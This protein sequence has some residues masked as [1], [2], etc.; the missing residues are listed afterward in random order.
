MP[1]IAILTKVPVYSGHTG[2]A[3]RWRA[4]W[5]ESAALRAGADVSLSDAEPNGPPR[6]RKGERP[7]CA[8]SL[9]PAARRGVQAPRAARAIGSRSVFGRAILCGGRARRRWRRRTRARRRRRRR[10]LRRVLSGRVFVF[11]IA[12]QALELIDEEQ[13]VQR[14]DLDLLAARLADHL[15][16]YA[17]EMVS[18]LGE[19][20]PVALVGAGRQPILFDA[21]HP[22][23]RVLVGAPAPRA[24]HAQR[25]G[26]VAIGE[27]GAFVEGHKRDLYRQTPGAG[28]SNAGRPALFPSPC[29]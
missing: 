5:R 6:A 25:T 8:A 15:I 4:A 22:A 19:L 11:H 13:R 27:E 18:Q 17:D 23:D 7:R 20:R 10:V 14:G 1:V 21:P 29:S 9:A 2:R 16:V 12:R 26:F 3:S 24:R 28:S